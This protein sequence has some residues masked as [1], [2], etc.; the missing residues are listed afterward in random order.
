MNGVKREIT[1]ACHLKF[2]AYV[3]KK[4][5]EE[6]KTVEDLNTF[7]AIIRQDFPTYRTRELQRIFNNTEKAARVQELDLGKGGG[8]RK[9]GEHTVMRKHN[10]LGIR[11]VKPEANR[12][13]ALHEIF[14]EVKTKFEGWRS[15]GHYVDRMDLLSEFE[16]KLKELIDKLTKKSEIAGGVLGLKD[17]K[18][19]TAANKRW[20]GHIASAKR[21]EKTVLQMQKLFNARFLTPNRLVALTID[22]EK[23]RVLEGW[24]AWDYLQWMAAF[25]PLEVLGEHIIQPEKFREGL[26]SAVICMSDQ[27]P[28]FIKLRP[29]KQLYAEG[30]YAETKTKYP[31][32]YATGG[33]SQKVETLVGAATTTHLRGESHGTQ[34][35]F[36][37]TVDLEQVCYGW[38]DD[39][40]EP[41][42]GW[43]ITSIILI[44]AHFREHNVVTHDGRHFWKEDESFCVDGKQV[45]RKKGDP[46]PGGLGSAILNFRSANPELFEKMKENK[47]R[48]YQ[49]PAAFEDAV[50]TKWKIKEQQ[51]VHGITISLKDMFTGG[52]S[53]SARDEMCLCHQLGEFIRFVQFS[54]I[55]PDRYSYYL[56]VDYMKIP[57][58]ICHGFSKATHR[59][60]KEMYRFPEERVT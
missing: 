35:K 24:W 43:G 19:L 6:N 54:P 32:A 3:L 10:G 45:S 16:T 46:V 53:E 12:K 55:S 7:M 56:T 33:G 60:L 28:Y 4:L 29:G 18:T 13:S 14:M 37:I 11:V 58:N 38:F 20:T 9:Q 2:R 42:A 50:I 44:G 48:F 5:A 22:Q 26:K 31:E 57:K 49:Q 36:R 47:I 34:D 40:V 27:M 21:Q 23:K 15:V 39:Q 1:A 52:L 51:V 59:L 30:E 41:K 17:T 8:R 25:A